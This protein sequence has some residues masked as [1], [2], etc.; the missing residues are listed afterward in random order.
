MEVGDVDGNGKVDKGWGTFIVDNAAARELN[1][2]IA[3]PL[4]DSRTQDEGLAIF[5]ATNSRTF[6]LAG[7]RRDLGPM[8]P[9][10]GDPSCPASDVA[11]NTDT[12]FHVVTEELAAFYGAS[13]WT[14]LQFHGNQTCPETDIHLSYGVAGP[15]S[16]SDK[17]TVLQ[18]QLLQ[19]HP[20]WIV[21][22][23][24]KPGDQCA[25]DGTTN[26]E[27]RFL[28]EGTSARRFV[29]IEQ[30]MDNVRTDRRDANN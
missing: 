6:L 12:M 30:Y 18:T 8:R 14:Q 29:H 3:H 27:G 9:C 28:N 21:T 10:P 23:F 2:A 13:D 17:L 22:A 15:F 16:S 7:A 5:K 26:V 20:D 11:H 4:D 25:L 24:G 19:H 1:I